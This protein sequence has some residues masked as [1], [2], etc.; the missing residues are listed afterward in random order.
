MRALERRLRAMEV[1]RRALTAMCATV[2]TRPGMHATQ[3]DLDAFNT[4]LSTARER[5]GPLVILTLNRADSLTKG[6]T[7]HGSP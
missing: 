3:A 5:G 1:V 2:L 6:G 7:C 4:Q